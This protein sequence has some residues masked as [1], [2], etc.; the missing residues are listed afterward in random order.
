M[1][2]SE[3]PETQAW[4]RSKALRHIREF[5]DHRSDLEQE[6]LLGL[7]RAEADKDCP[8]PTDVERFRGFASRCIWNDLRY[9]ARKLRQERYGRVDLETLDEDEGLE[10]IEAPAEPPKCD[11]LEFRQVVG[12][13]LKRNRRLVFLEAY[14]EDRHRSLAEVAEN[15]GLALNYVKH[16]HALAMETIRDLSHFQ[17]VA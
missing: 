2:P 14:G 9:Y 5:P 11:W 3:D 15:T 4:A 13:R 17:R 6:A 16:Q 1:R 7:V 10:A 8:D 12:G